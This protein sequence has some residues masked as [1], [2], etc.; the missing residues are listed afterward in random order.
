[1]N[2]ILK[3]VKEEFLGD[4]NLEVLL[5]YGSAVS[6]KMRGDS[7]VDVAVLYREPLNLEYRMDLIERLEG[8]V[9]RNIDLVD[10]YALN[11]VILK[12]IL[13]KGTVLIKNSEAAYEGLLHR[14]VYNQ[15]DMMPYYH[16]A[17]KTRLKGFLH[18]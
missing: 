2:E 11:G 10:L 4:Q 14:M 7:D 5:L 15:Q 3:L 9:H 13:T 16:R 6:G 8:K 12:K 1:V 17:L 18:G